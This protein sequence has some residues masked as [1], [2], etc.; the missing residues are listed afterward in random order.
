MTLARRYSANPI[1]SPD[2]MAAWEK[3]ATFNGCPVQDD[4]KTYLLY[5][6]VSEKTKVD[7]LELNLSTIGI[8]ES[9]DRIHFTNRRQL[10]KPEEDWEKYGCEDPRVTKMGKNYYIFYTALSQ[11]PPSADSI[12]TAVAVTDDLGKI[13]ERHLVTP[14][15][16]KAMALFS[17]KINGKYAAILTV[18]TDRPPAKIAV[19][20]FES[21]SQIWDKSFWNNWYENLDKFVIPLLRSDNDHLEVG[22]PPLIT[23][24]GWLLIYSYIK[25]YFSGNKTFSIEAVLLDTNSP[26]TKIEALETPLL[27]PQEDYEISGQ[28]PNIVFPSGALI[29]NGDLGIYYGAADTTCCLAVAKLDAV[30]D[31]LKHIEYV[32][33]NQDSIKP[34]FVRFSDNPIISP[35]HEHE[36][37]SKFTLNAAA[38]FEAQKVHILYRA[39]GKDGTSVLGYAASLD[40]IHIDERLPEPVYVPREDFEKSQKNGFSGCEDPRVTKIGDRF[41]MCY[42]AYNGQDPPRVALTSI[43][44]SDFLEKNWVWDKPVLISPPGEMDKNACVLPKKIDGRYGF[45]HRLGQSI[46]FDLVDS[47]KF[48]GQ[49]GFLMGNIILK[50]RPD[51][52]DSLKIGIGP[53]PIETA[54][55]WILI[56]HGLSNFDNKYRLGAALLDLKNPKKVISRLEY[57]I[58]EPIETYENKGLRIGTVFSCG[59][60]VLNRRIFLYYGGADQFI[61]VAAVEINKLLGEL[62]K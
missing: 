38:I 19:A 24:N 25:N 22:A 26:Q 41:Y 36:W 45:F 49:D 13:K 12:K 42:T 18:D 57:P 10:I 53:V 32:E 27:T 54:A 56:Y 55:G 5:R 33:P 46:W 21:L 59:A 16:S 23:N 9:D 50:P 31:K 11:F 17:E 35:I 39:Q 2:K 48:S 62:K 3:I 60:V 30:L 58:L 47:L 14:F 40:G 43:S 7:G 1:L 6:A 20:Y 28:V 34:I 51:K 37:E 15:N 4:N 44:V 52:W 29:H 8:C 61:S